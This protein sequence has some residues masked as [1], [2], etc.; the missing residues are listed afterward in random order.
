MTVL[1]GSEFLRQRF[2][3]HR[4][5]QGC[6]SPERV[7]RFFDEL[8]GV[9]FPQRSDRSFET[10]E[11]FT[12]T[13]GELERGL[14]ETLEGVPE[15]QRPPVEATA[16]RFFR[17][18]PVLFK[19]ME[20][21]ARATFEGDPA[22]VDLAEVIRVY[23]GFYAIAAYRVA[24]EL[25]RLGV[26]MVP[27]MITE[28]AHSRTGVD[29]HPG[30][31]IGR[32]FCID[33]GTGVVIGETTEIGDRVKVYQGVT[34]GGLS[35][36]KGDAQTKRHPTIEDDVVI[37]AGATILGGQTVI[38]RGSVIGGNVWLTRSVPAGSRLSYR[39]V[40]RDDGVASSDTVE[41]EQ[42]PA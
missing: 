1:R 24:H 6:P 17:E 13:V 8:L 19:R 3:A 32:S 21:D 41:I 30:A 7:A 31:R 9:L 40:L 25:L 5:C 2:T 18:L 10:L 38:G 39:T 36:R 27:R 34:L 37:Y 42:E 4:E 22:A 11:A 28:H 33:H 15:R 16:Q 23:P 35:V 26:P 14:A 12:T 29:V 20:E